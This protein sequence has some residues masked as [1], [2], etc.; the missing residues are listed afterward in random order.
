MARKN[1]ERQSNIKKVII[2]LF[3]AFI[4][5][6]SILAIMFS[7]YNQPNEIEYNGHIFKFQGDYLVTKV[8]KTTIKIQ[9][10]PANLAAI[11]AD[12]AIAQ[13]LNSGYP[14]FISTPLTAQYK[15]Y[16]GQAA[17]DLAEYLGTI[18]VQTSIAIS[19]DNT[20][21]PTIPLITCTNATAALPVLIFEESNQSSMSI[22]GDCIRISASTGYD[23][24]AY[25]DRLVLKLSGIMP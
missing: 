15:E 8:D 13:K 1:T 6:S 16:A 21:Y 10:Y 25:K 17:Y 22:E 7:G 12:D 3:F 5:V 20:G 19:D 9:S 24:I 14:I 23:F 18:G 11:Q 2:S 4:M